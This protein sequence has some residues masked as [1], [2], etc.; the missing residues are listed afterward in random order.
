[1]AAESLGVRLELIEI[2][3]V[4]DLEAAFRT[5]KRKKV[6]AVML[7][8]SPIFFVSRARVAAL[9]LGGRLPTVSAYDYAT[10]A[11]ALMSYGT[12]TSGNW[13]R[14]AYYVDRLLKGAKP[15][16]LPVEQLPKLKLAVN[17]KTAKALGINIPETILLRADEVIR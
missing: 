7:Q 6:G 12:D 16:D 5:A 4:Q 2:R 8:G 1:S 14:T 3:K 11:G 15:G 17:L 13:K 10:A 9:A